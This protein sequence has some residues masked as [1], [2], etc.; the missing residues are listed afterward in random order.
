MPDKET[1][2]ELYQRDI[3]QNAGNAAEQATLD[4]IN[5]YKD[6]Y[7][8][9]KDLTDKDKC[10]F[11]D[12]P[13]NTE[14]A[15]EMLKIYQQYFDR[16]YENKSGTYKA[17]IRSVKEQFL[18]I[19]NAADNLPT[20]ILEKTNNF[21]SIADKHSIAGMTIVSPVKTAELNTEA[22]QTLC[23]ELDN[24]FKPD[25]PHFDPVVFDNLQ[26]CF[27]KASNIIQEINS[28]ITQNN[29]LIVNYKEK[30]K[31]Q[32]DIAKQI[33]N[34]KEQK[35]LLDLKNT[36]IAEKKGEKQK[37]LEKAQND[38][39][40]LE[41]KREK[42]ANDYKAYIENLPR[43]AATSMQDIVN[44]HF[45]LN[46]TLESEPVQFVRTKEFPFK[47]KLCDGS[48]VERSINDGLSEGERQILSLAF[49]FA[50]LENFPRQKRMVVFDDPVN[51]V[52]SRNLKILA[53]LI[54]DRCQG[55][56][57]IIFTHHPLFY[58]Y[59]TKNLAAIS[60]SVIKNKQKFGGSFIY[61]EKPLCIKD[62][63]EQMNNAL[64]SHIKNDELNYEMFTLEYG[65]L[66]RYS[67]ESFIRNKLLHWDK[68]FQNIV[69]GIR[70]N[71]LIEDDV[72]VSIQKIY[73]RGY[74]FRSP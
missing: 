33:K 52:D 14:A 73:K 54:K 11:C 18:N 32:A 53:D 15:G 4:K 19:K 48:G 26:T 29:D 36:F 10:P 7:K 23:T 20:R 21:Q 70:K 66:L 41:Q 56:Q 1:I 59:A 27:D 37:Q 67:V 62:K 60:F 17:D 30:N 51:S 38:Q 28:W 61:R 35:R 57:V 72:L 49:F 24:L 25:K 65:H 42:A 40:K 50:H 64:E 63:L 22:I 45:K 68:P 55:N 71:Q 43:Q 34:K 16:A 12:Q 46:F 9:H 13:L 6:F 58:K 74:P 39:K 44:N 3:K 69:D 2:K 8:A 47:F 31:S 5:Q